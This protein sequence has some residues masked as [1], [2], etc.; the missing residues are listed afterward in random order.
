MNF[1]IKQ[2]VK[3][4]ALRDAPNEACGFISVNSFGD[5]TVLPCENMARNKTNRFAI[6]PRK[7][8]EAEKLG[9]VAAFYHSH[10]SDILDKS[11]DRFSSED[12]DTSYE[13]CIPALL[14]VQAS[15]SWHYSQPTTYE[16]APLLGRP[17]VGGIW[18]CYSIVRDYHK[19]NNKVSMGY[20]FPPDN[21]SSM[22]N[23]GYE[24]NL[25]KENFHEI[26]LAE[27]TTGD[28]FL[29]KIRSNFINHCGVYLGDNQFIHQPLNSISTESMLD[30]KYI[31]KIHKVM[32]LND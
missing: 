18:D 24:E 20:Y 28:V 2:K 1:S 10:C 30:E 21:P 17:F 8:I 4:H 25:S 22:C 13:S 26:D 14:Y 9:H 12:L 29:F 27:A 15:D 32:R 6:D 31:Q 23:F 19:M 3:D 11:V 5:V 16:P 7:N